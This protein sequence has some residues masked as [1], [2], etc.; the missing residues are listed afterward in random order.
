METE[1]A[2]NVIEVGAQAKPE[3]ET[4]ACLME[5]VVSADDYLRIRK[6]DVLVLRWNLKLLPSDRDKIRESIE[7]NIGVKVV[8]LEP[9]IDVIGVVEHGA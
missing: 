3:D 9:V 4:T 8:F 1:K 6:D 5:A 7:K 2:R